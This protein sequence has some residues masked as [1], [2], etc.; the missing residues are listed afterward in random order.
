MPALGIAAVMA[1][2]EAH[3]CRQVIP[4]LLRLQEVEPLNG[5]AIGIRRECFSRRQPGVS[6]RHSAPKA[7][8]LAYDLLSFSRYPE[9]SACWNSPNSADV[10]AG[11]NDGAI[12]NVEGDRNTDASQP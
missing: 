6:A 2:C 5:P 12:W 7:E 9:A 8:T 1:G 11:L 3:A 10:Y 4:A